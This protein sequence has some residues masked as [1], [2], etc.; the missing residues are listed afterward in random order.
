MD[1]HA[2]LAPHDPPG[3]LPDNAAQGRDVYLFACEGECSRIYR[4]REGAG[5]TR[6]GVRIVYPLDEAEVVAT[7][8]PDDPPYEM[9][10]RPDGQVRAVRMRFTH[11]G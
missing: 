10:V 3:P 5:E 2:S 4:S 8:G 11:R 7:L 9:E 6:G 1:A